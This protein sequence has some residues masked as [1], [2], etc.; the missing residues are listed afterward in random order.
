MRAH[1]IIS[2]LSLGII[3][4][5]A[6]PA[7]AD[8]PPFQLMDATIASVHAALRNHAITCT[9]LTQAYLSRIAAYDKKGPDLNAVLTLNPNAV[10]EAKAYD[11][12][13]PSSFADRPLACV[14]IVLKDNYDTADLRTT[15]GSV[16]LAAA[17]PAADAFVVAKLRRAGAIVLGKA[18]MQEFALGGNTTSS[19]G[20]QTKNPYDLMRTPGGSSGGTGAALAANFALAGTGSDTVNSLRSPAS[21]NSLVAIRPTRGLV[22]TAGIIPVSFT[23]DAVGPLA[24]TVAD[25][26][27]MLDVM[28]GPNPTD[29]ASAASKG[30]IPATYTAFVTTGALRGARIGVLQNFF[31]TGPEHA[32]VNR[33]MNAAIERMRRAGATVVPITV[34]GIDTDALNRDDDVQ[35]YEFK[36]VFNAYLAQYAPTAAVKS[37]HELVATGKYDP[38]LEGFL[39][40]ADVADDPLKSAEYAARI[41]RAKQLAQTIRAAMDDNHVLALVYPEQKRLVVPIGTSQVDRNGILAGMTGF[42][43]ISIPAGFSE[44]TATAPLGVP[45]GMEIF[46]R[47]WDEGTLFRLASSFE[48]LEPVRRMPASTPPLAGDLAAR[49]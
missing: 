3:T 42:P 11:S 43:S 48:A 6:A 31:G 29:P 40:S 4:G 39:K 1:V 27:Q 20:G 30:H 7:R 34:P 8:A 2:L 46:G 26:A 49:N 41:A 12:A 14:P 9:G 47:P 36:G 44:P 19:L 22:S 21:A 5:A 35:K 24:R 45:V 32:E 16:E 38:T 17:R 33:V 15:G 23:Q 37:L 10:A 18:N 13:P 25:A 28:A